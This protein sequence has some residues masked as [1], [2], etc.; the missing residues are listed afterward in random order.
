ANSRVDSNGVRT[1][2]AASGPIVAT[3]NGAA[4]AP[5]RSPTRDA[6]PSRAIAAIKA[7]RRPTK[8]VARARVVALDRN[9]SAHRSVAGRVRVRS[10]VRRVAALT[11]RP[12]AAVNRTTAANGIR[13]HKA[14]A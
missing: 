11:D 12:A 13:R 1:R 4:A 6:T 8:A 3:R 2:V 9:G 5:D 10:T 7:G 14:A